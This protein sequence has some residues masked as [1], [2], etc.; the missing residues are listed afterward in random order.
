MDDDRDTQTHAASD[1]DLVN[2]VYCRH[3]TLHTHLLGDRVTSAIATTTPGLF[4][5]V[6]TPTPCH[7]SYRILTR[8]HLANCEAERH[9]AHRLL[10]KY[11]QKSQ[12][13]KLAQ[14][15]TSHCT[16]AGWMATPC[17]SASI[18]SPQTYD[19]GRGLM[20]G[21]MVHAYTSTVA[22]SFVPATLLRTFWWQPAQ[23]THW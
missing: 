5:Q 19:R 14:G 12:C 13:E 10:G 6:E 1:G 17:F 11:C 20:L 8:L 18:V 7:I 21:A 9:A 3:E 15:S 4:N 2:R 22:S 16:R 23:H